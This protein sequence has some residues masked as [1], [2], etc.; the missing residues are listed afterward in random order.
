MLKDSAKLNVSL[1]TSASEDAEEKSL[2][3][4]LK[5]Q[6]GAVALQSSGVKLTSDVT[7]TIAG[8]SGAPFVFGGKEVEKFSQRVTD[9]VQS[10]QF[11][12]ELSRVIGTPLPDET[13]DEF[14]KRAKEKM[15]GLLRKKF[16][17]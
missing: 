5:S 17:M 4:Y 12:D 11:T 1:A 7:A 8:F 15:T 2:K 16:S 9:I 3:R 6:Q 14:V 13:E 10:E